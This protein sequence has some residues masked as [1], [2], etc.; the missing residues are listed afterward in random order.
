MSAVSRLFWPASIE[1]LCCV[2]DTAR[3]EACAHVAAGKDANSNNDAMMHNILLCVR[4]PTIIMGFI[5]GS[6]DSSILPSQSGITA[7]WEIYITFGYS[8]AFM[9]ESN[10]DKRA[11]KVFIEK[12]GVEKKEV[13]EALVFSLITYNPIQILSSHCGT[14]AEE[15]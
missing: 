2:I 1:Y 14:K 6:S 7:A 15:K 11:L 9:F 8:C 10:L 13:K 5:T 4:P 12:L 3:G